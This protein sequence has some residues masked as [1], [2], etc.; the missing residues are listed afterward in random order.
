MS[1]TTVN[2][3]RLD[4]GTPWRL[5][6]PSSSDETWAVLWLQGFTSTVAGHSQNCERLANE[7]GI[8]VALLDYQGHGENPVHLED[9]VRS[10]Q[11]TEVMAVYDELVAR[12]YQKIIV[13]G[14]SF[15]S[16]MAAL[17]ASE[18]TPRAIVLRAPA[19]YPDEEFDIA[20]SQTSRFK[21]KGFYV[22]WK[23]SVDEDFSNMPIKAISEYQGEVFVIEHGAD[24]VV[25]SS[26][27]R[28]YYRAVQPG[29]ANY[30]VIP[31]L[32]HTANHMP[33][34]AKWYKITEAWLKTIIDTVRIHDE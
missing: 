25:P 9:S 20:Y 33:D 17:L 34:A 22:E 11:L 15:G 19:N 21:Q 4:L 30:I 28:A 2:H 27:P 26:F 14:G 31:E 6:V 8:T 16:Y 32:I 12:G 3:F 5:I 23:K 7:A 18:R 1:G 24:E 13:I 10:E 29:R